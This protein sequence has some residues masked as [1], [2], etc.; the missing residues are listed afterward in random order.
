MFIEYR[1]VFVW[2]CVVL[3]SDLMVMVIGR[4]WRFIDNGSVMI[5]IKLVD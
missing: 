2:F 3:E 4:Y 5:E 1:R